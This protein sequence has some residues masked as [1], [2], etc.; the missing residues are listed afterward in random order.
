MH[1]ELRPVD[2]V[3]VHLLQSLLVVLIELDPLPK[4]VGSMCTFRCLHVKV[5]DT[6]LLPDGSIL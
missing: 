5:A 1:N 2:E 3:F 4:L 6:L